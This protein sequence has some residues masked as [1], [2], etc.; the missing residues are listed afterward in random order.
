M[1]WKRR[2]PSGTTRRRRRCSRTA[3][4]TPRPCCMSPPSSPRMRSRLCLSGSCPARTGY[5]FAS[6]S[7]F[8][9]PVGGSRR[10]KSGQ[11]FPPI[12]PR[13]SASLSTHPRGSGQPFVPFQAKGGQVVNGRG[14][15][16]EVVN[17]GVH[18]WWGSALGAMGPTPGPTPHCYTP[19]PTPGTTYEPPYTGPYTAIHMNHHTP[20]PTP[21]DT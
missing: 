3:W 17:R 19:D 9:T 15:G 10:P 18:E 2:S 13:G 8:H 14:A 5:S 6:H 16:D 12:P 11:P 21:P 20:G 1:G 4:L 7:V